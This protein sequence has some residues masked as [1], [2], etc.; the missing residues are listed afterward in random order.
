MIISQAEV[1]LFKKTVQNRM[2]IVYK[3]IIAFLN[4]NKKERNVNKLNFFP[5]L[6]I[7]FVSIYCTYFTFLTLVLCMW[8]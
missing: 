6:I 1:A 7:A 4:F 8:T 5:R 3:E 2:I